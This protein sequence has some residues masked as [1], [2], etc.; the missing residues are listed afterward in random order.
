MPKLEWDQ[1]S[2]MPLELRKV[3]VKEMTLAELKQ[4]A[5]QI[6]QILDQEIIEE[7]ERIQRFILEHVLAMWNAKCAF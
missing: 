1:I 5:I 3:L 2:A 6:I 7:D 4:N